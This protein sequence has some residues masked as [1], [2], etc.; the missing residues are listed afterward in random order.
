MF[1]RKHA[2]QISNRN[3][4]PIGCKMNTRASVL[5][6]FLLSFAL[7]SCGNNKLSCDSKEVIDKILAP[8]T[9]SGDATT[10]QLLKMG[11]KIKVVNIKTEKVESD[12]TCLCEA[13]L[14]IDTS[15]VEPNRSERETKVTL[16]FKYKVSLAPNGKDIR[17]EKLR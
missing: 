2:G 11:A 14:Y 1:T 16:P 6:L 10:S 7:P 8:I 17:Y 12:G 4:L 9:Q 5:I 15:A 13:G 3:K